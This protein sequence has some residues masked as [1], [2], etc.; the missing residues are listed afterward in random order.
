MTTDGI[1][2]AL[3]GA[4]AALQSKGCEAEI[5]LTTSEER[6]AEELAEP[7]RGRRFDCS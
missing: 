4:R 6:I 7:V 5:L 3:N 2:S 1:L